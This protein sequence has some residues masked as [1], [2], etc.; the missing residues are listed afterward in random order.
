MIWIS[1]HGLPDTVHV[2]LRGQSGRLSRDNLA[3]LAVIL[4]LSDAHAGQRTYTV[5]SSNLNLPSGSRSI[6]RLPRR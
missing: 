2:E 6:A 3:G 1:A 5:H 4:D